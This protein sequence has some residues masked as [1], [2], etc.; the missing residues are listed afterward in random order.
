MRERAIEQ[1]RAYLIGACAKH[2]GNIDNYLENP[3]G[4]YALI[5]RLLAELEELTLYQGML[6]ALASFEYE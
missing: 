5:D 1:T 6:E 2:T 3:E 4:S